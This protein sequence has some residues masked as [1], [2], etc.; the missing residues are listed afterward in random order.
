MRM[1][2]LILS[3]TLVFADPNNQ[4]ELDIYLYENDCENN[5]CL[6]WTIFVENV[7]VFFR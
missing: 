5:V 1:I 3:F 6:N 4:T 2:G 7:G